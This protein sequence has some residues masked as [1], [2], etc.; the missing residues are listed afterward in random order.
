MG[1]RGRRSGSP[2]ELAQA[3]CSLGCAMRA[4]RGGP[5][6]MPRAATR[7]PRLLSRFGWTTGPIFFSR[8]AC[9]WCSF[10]IALRPAGVLQARRGNTGSSWCEAPAVPQDGAVGQYW[11]R[12]SRPPLPHGSVLTTRVA[13]IGVEHCRRA[14]AGAGVR[15][16]SGPGPGA[17]PG[18]HRGEAAVGRGCSRVPA[19]RSGTHVSS[20]ALCCASAVIRAPGG[21]CDPR[22]LH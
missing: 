17:A 4:G 12:A 3:G 1:H 19:A 22:R 2:T 21:P 13:G 20:C 15:A 7:G 18:G 6:R 10:R 9:C 14:Q 8:A 5:A 16:S 11:G